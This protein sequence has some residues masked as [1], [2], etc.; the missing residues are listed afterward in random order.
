MKHFTLQAKIARYSF[1][2]FDILYKLILYNLLDKY[3]C[4]SRPADSI[5][6]V[7][8]DISNYLVSLFDIKQVFY[9]FRK[10]CIHCN[11]SEFW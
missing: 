5:A 7:L 1:F 4:L 10:I 3:E 9:V 11:V 2:S 6:K 8:L